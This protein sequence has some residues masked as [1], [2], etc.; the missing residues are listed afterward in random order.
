MEPTDQLAQILPALTDLAEGIRPEQLGDPTP[1]S[2]FTV[3]DIL[4]HILVLGGSFAH[5]YRGEPVPPI[6]PSPRNGQVPAARVRDTLTGLLDAIRSPGA[7]DR[8]I[9]APVGEV[10]GETFARLLAFD[11]LIHGWDLAT[12]T[13]QPYEVPEAVVADVDDFVRVALTDDLRDGDTFKDATTAPEEASRLEQLVA[14]SGR[15]L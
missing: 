12:A 3:Q 9:S 4:D 15:T 13:G 11:G 14:F 7:L 8:T 5:Q 6:D 1:C 2:D 10:P